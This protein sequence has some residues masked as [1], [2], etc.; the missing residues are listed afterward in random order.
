[1]KKSKLLL[2]GLFFLVFL[3]GLV[4]IIIHDSVS[5]S[6]ILRSLSNLS[7][8]VMSLIALPFIAL[9]LVLGVYLRRKN[10]ERKWKQALKKTRAKK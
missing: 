2:L 3:L 5:F 8:R 9:L 7:P 6:G 1:M 4:V 10:E